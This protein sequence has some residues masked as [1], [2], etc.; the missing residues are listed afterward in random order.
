MNTRELH[1]GLGLAVCGHLPAPVAAVVRFAYLTGWRVKS[2]VLTLEW[3]NVDTKA[4][5]ITLDAEHSK[6]G[7]PRTFPYA[8]FEPVKTLID[9]QAAERD[10]L[11]AEGTVCARVFHRDGTPIKSFRAAWASACTA[12]GYPGRISHDMRRSAARNL[13][14]SGVSE[15]VAMKLLGHKTRSVFDRY[16]VTSGDDKVA[17]LDL[18]GK[19]LGQPDAKTAKSGPVVPMHKKSANG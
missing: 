4:K 16:D 9:G 15:N 1:A 6:N 18:L 10:R 7:E 17:A 13:V 14:R 3:R 12:A 19:L 8:S 5:V 11:K 2:E